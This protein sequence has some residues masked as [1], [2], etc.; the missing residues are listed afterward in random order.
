MTGK[1]PSQA[2]HQMAPWLRW[3]A[4]VGIVA[5]GAIYLLIG[6]LAL[7]GAFDPS[8]HPSGSSGAMSRLAHVPLGRVMLGLLALGLLAYVAWQLVLVV[9]D[10]ECSER[11]WGIRRLAL[12]FH[13]LWSA[14]LHCALVGIAAWQM[15][16]LGRADDDGQTQRQLAAVVLRLT[17]G[18]WL[19]VG[20]GVGIVGFALAQWVAACRPQKQTR[21]E[22]ADTPLRR[23]I[24]ALLSLGYFARGVLFGVIGAFLLHAAW[25]HDPAKVTGVSGALESLRR[26]PYGP[27]LLGVVAIGLIGFALAQMARARYRDLEV[28]DEARERS[29]LIGRQRK[30]RD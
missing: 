20:I 27:W 6:G 12:R 28:V 22:L 9:M 13:H 4:R 7:A 18:R 25:Q 30:D 11:R 5:E 14:V 26:Q 21:M 2:Q 19:L 3:G 24:L 10:P 16:Q 8:L 17:G 1:E 15:V 23:P 29:D